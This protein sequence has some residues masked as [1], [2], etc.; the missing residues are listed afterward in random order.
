MLRQL[1]LFIH[2]LL[3]SSLFITTTRNSETHKTHAAQLSYKKQK[4]YRAHSF[5]IIYSARW[6]RCEPA[7][8]SITIIS[9]LICLLYRE[10]LKS[11]Q[12]GILL[13]DQSSARA[14]LFIEKVLWKLKY[15]LA[16]L[17]FFVYS[18]S[19][20]QWVCG[21]GTATCKCA[22]LTSHQVFGLTRE[23]IITAVDN[24][25]KA[26]TNVP[27]TLQLSRCYYPFQWK[28][29]FLWVHSSLV[30][31]LKPSL[32]N[33]QSERYHLCIYIGPTIRYIQCFFTMFVWST[34]I[35]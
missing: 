20:Q 28:G 4:W 5:V 6:M 1:W 23:P 27:I 24:H 26:R 12:P 18:R 14:P 3:L 33:I 22:A 8:L 35:R 31:L 16:C 9:Q 11:T 25:F 21:L 34:L 19:V 7:P 13:V 15:F 10:Y 29:K 30:T 17:F 32:Y 2:R